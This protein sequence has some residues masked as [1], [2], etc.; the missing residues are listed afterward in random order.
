PNPNLALTL[1][2][3][4]DRVETMPALS[5][6]LIEPTEAGTYRLTKTLAQICASH[7]LSAPDGVT[8]LALRPEEK[9]GGG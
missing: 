3:P 8:L 4:P 9:A 5:A 7:S 2:V 6:D 1:G